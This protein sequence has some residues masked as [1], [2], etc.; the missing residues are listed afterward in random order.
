M[1]LQVMSNEGCRSFSYDDFEEVKFTFLTIVNRPGVSF[2]F[3]SKGFGAT[4]GAAYY[5][6]RRIN[7]YFLCFSIPTR[8][9]IPIVNRLFATTEVRDKIVFCEA[10]TIAFH[11][12]I[13]VVKLLRPTL[14][15]AIGAFP[16]KPNLKGDGHTMESAFATS[17]AGLLRRAHGFDAG[18]PVGNGNALFGVDGCRQP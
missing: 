3:D 18:H 11:K 2:C 9:L 1:F 8:V 16:P 6:R 17:R 10:F 4:Q 15:S 12:A 14:P 7:S 13:I 5:L